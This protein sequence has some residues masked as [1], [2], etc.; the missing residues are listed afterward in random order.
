[1]GNYVAT[2]Q[3]LKAMDQ[4]PAEQSG[5]LAQAEAELT[6]LQAN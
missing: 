3:S 6:K 5:W 1:V 4:L 2:L